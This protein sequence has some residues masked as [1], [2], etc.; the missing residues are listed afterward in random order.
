MSRIDLNGCD[1]RVIV[2]N[3]GRYGVRIDKS[4]EEVSIRAVNLTRCDEDKDLTPRVWLRW[5]GAAQWEGVRLPAVRTAAYSRVCRTVLV[6]GGV[7]EDHDAEVGMHA[8]DVD[9]RASRHVTEERDGEP[10]A[11][12]GGGLLVEMSATTAVMLC[13]QGDG[14]HGDYLTPYLLTVPTE[15]DDSGVRA[16]MGYGDPAATLE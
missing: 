15:P 14:P 1:A 16:R 7:G 3:G 5:S 2:R 12:R 13:G 4:G 6:W 10:P 8:I 9:R 11:P